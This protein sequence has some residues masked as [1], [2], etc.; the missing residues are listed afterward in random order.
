MNTPSFSVVKSYFACVELQRFCLDPTAAPSAL[1]FARLLRCTSQTSLPSLRERADTP[2]TV[3]AT[4]GYA[5][6]SG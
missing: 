5:L 4:T 3:V 2:L 6:R 1:W